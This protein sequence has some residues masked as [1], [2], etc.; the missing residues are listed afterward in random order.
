MVVWV[1]FTLEIRH[2]LCCQSKRFLTQ[3]IGGSRR[4][5][6]V[7]N[8][9]N[10]SMGTDSFQLSL[11]SGRIAYKVS[12]FFVSGEYSIILNLLIKFSFIYINQLIWKL[13]K[14]HYFNR[15][16]LYF[17]FSPIGTLQKY[18]NKYNDSYVY[19]IY[20]FKRKIIHHIYTL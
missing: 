11:H 7:S 5:R 3:K 18:T 19:K 10:A 13:A 15:Y 17:D 20:Q 1:L 2:W 4:Y 16:L 14:L 9:F 12:C 6:F 8:G